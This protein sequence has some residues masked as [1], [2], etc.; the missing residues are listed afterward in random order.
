MRVI[1]TRPLPQGDRTAAIVASRGHQPVLMPL[2]EIH[3]TEL[4]PLAADPDSY[5]MVVATSANALVHAPLALT[6]AL[7]DIPF[8]GVGAATEHAALACGFSGTESTSGNADDLARHIIADLPSGAR[9]AYLCGRVRKPDLEKNLAEAGLEIDALETYDTVLVSYTTD[10]LRE[11]F[12]TGKPLAVLLYSRNAA[13]RLADLLKQAGMAN[14]TDFTSFFC[15]SED[16]AAPLRE[17]GFPAVAVAAEPT[18]AALLNLLETT[19]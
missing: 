13:Q 3:P 1:V 6:Q 16:V 5:A 9:V 7:R 14:I 12:V 17:A 19:R 11:Q 8:V 10:F 2:T 15:L 4:R 18:E